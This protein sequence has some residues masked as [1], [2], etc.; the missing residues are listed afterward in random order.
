MQLIDQ[1][2][3]KT[4]LQ[5]ATGVAKKYLGFIAVLSLFINLAMLAVPIYMLQLYDR[6]LTSRNE[7]TLYLLTAV[8]IVMLISLAALEL[9]RSRILI[10]IGRWFDEQ[11]RTWLVY[12]SINNGRDSQAIRDLDDFRTFL[13]GPGLLALIDAPWTPLYIA[14]VYLLHPVLGSIVVVGVIVLAGLAFLNEYTTRK[15]L[16]EAGYHANRAHRFSDLV[17]RNAEAIRAMSM[18]KALI[19]RWEI[20]RK[21]AVDLQTT[22][23]D[24]IGI[25]SAAAKFSRLLLQVAVLGVGGYLAI[26][27]IISPGVMITTSIIAARALAPI[28]MAI[29]SWRN[30]IIA[31]DAYQ[32]LNQFLL[33][34]PESPSNMPLPEPKGQLRLDHVSVKATGR[35]QPILYN[36]NFELTP[37][38]QLGITGPSAAGKSTLART[39]VGVMTS[40]T[41]AVR[42]DGFDIQSWSP[43]QLGA[44]IGY[45]P[46]DVELFDG[47]IDENIARFNEI[48]SE[49]II[50]AAK[51]ASVYDMIAALPDGFSTQIGQGGEYLSGGQRQRIALARAL[52]GDPKLLIL[53]EPS[54]NLDSDGDHALRNA[55]IEVR[56]QGVTVVV[57]AHRPNLLTQVDKIMVM[58]QGQITLFGDTAEILPQITKCVVS[59]DAR[60]KRPAVKT[61]VKVKGGSSIERAIGVT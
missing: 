42:I 39:I 3:E 21:Q 23:S 18:S 59:E 34:F 6:V 49:A 11:L 31:R 4:Q 45:V 5:L 33:E 36:I 13:T 9:V 8:T 27:E 51:K 44:H 37:G 25:I 40:T 53:D 14:A 61:Q 29:G 22:G 52:Y 47:R 20:E 60:N 54:S 58:E 2:K 19:T 56:K 12:L 55:L 17:A 38:Q 28:E 16:S 46:Q 24:R 30:V 10:R 35:D 43:A 57:I 7:N 15:V 48:D 50:A 26:Q 32:R 41:G 1:T